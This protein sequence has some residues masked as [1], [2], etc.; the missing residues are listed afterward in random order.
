MDTRC[1]PGDLA[2]VTRDYDGCDDNVGRIVVV[3]GPLTFCDYL[4]PKWLIAA[5]SDHPWLFREGVRIQ[6]TSGRLLFSDDVEHPDGWLHP[7]RGSTAKD[8]KASKR[9]KRRVA[10][11]ER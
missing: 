1:K 3:R 8:V 9:T 7:I 4:G 10:V 11:T 6:V 5:K 2:V